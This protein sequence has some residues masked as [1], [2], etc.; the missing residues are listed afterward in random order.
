MLVVR[1]QWMLGPTLQRQKTQCVPTLL[2]TSCL[3]LTERR[4]CELMLGFCHGGGRIWM[5][6]VTSQMLLTLAVMVQTMLWMLLLPQVA[7]DTA[8]PATQHLLVNASEVVD[9]SD[10]LHAALLQMLA[11]P[12]PPGHGPRQLQCAACLH[13]CDPGAPHATMLWHHPTPAHV[14]SAR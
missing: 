4:H 12:L 7:S 11:E 2:L 6:V 14:H 10:L 9:A 3:P 5:L 13:C 1:D 8:R